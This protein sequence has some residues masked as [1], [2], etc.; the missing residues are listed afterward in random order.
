MGGYGS[1][2]GD[3]PIYVKTVYEKGAASVDRRLK[4]GDQLIAVNGQSMEGVNHEEAVTILK[5]ASGVI[6]LAIIT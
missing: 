4:P 2:P 1:P 5:N 3:L 6:E